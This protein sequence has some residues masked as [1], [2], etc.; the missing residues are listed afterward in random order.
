[1]TSYFTRSRRHTRAPGDRT[2]LRAVPCRVPGRGSTVGRV[3]KAAALGFLCVCVIAIRATHLS[4]QEMGMNGQVGDSDAVISDGAVG[5]ALQGGGMSDDGGDGN[6]DGYRGGDC[7]GACDGYAPC[8]SCPPCEPCCDEHHLSGWFG[9]ECLHWRLDGNHL[10]PLVTAGP[11]N[12]PL[13]VVAQLDEPTTVVLVGRDDVN[14]DWR[15]GYRLFGGFWFDGCHTWGIGA[16]YFELGDDEFGFTSP[17]DPAFVVGRPFFNTQTGQN[18]LQLVSVPNELDGTA[19]VRSTDDFKGAGL[20]VNYC[21]WRSCDP[22]CDANCSGVT[23]LGGYRSY[24]YDTNL[25]ITEQ[26]TVLPGTTSP[27]VPGTTF[28]LQD[29]FG[30]RNEFHGVEFGLQAYKKHC[31]WWVDGMAKLAMG[32]K[33][34]TVT[35][36]GETFTV[37]PGGGTNLAAGGLLTSQLTNIG[38][39]DDSDF[40]VIPE[41]RFGAG[42]MV[43][44]HCSVRAGYNIIV[45]GDVARAASH[46]PPGL[47]VD[48]RNIPPIQNGGGLDPEFPGVHG[49]QLVAH[50]FDASIQWQW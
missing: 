47:Q 33:R 21:L 6:C 7:Y 27:L 15:N 31:W 20:T 11:A 42:A 24:K 35:V 41:F 19:V 10:P 4:A 13:N 8:D 36:D 12:L 26:L 38:H 28:D 44:C 18:D 1:M 39:Y 50:G 34:S 16:D 48:P 3:G 9:A 25:S 23:L 43:S 14:D 17:Q 2:T 5:P 32:G 37:V 30:T 45:W 40:A 49:S 46:L 22:C 29:S